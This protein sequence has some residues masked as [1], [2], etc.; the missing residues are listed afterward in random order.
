M[1]QILLVARHNLTGRTGQ[2]RYLKMTSTNLIHKYLFKGRNKVQ[3][4]Q[5]Q[6][7]VHIKMVKNGN[8]I[9]LLFCRP[10]NKTKVN[11]GKLEVYIIITLRSRSIQYIILLNLPGRWSTNHVFTLY[12][13]QSFIA[14][15]KFSIL[16]Y[17]YICSE[18]SSGYILSSSYVN[19]TT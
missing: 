7:K 18:L 15:W 17:F 13:N 16:I 6:N 2:D 4:L 1:Q 3:Y 11:S 9:F 5:E 12:E 8:R 19:N 14:S 10:C